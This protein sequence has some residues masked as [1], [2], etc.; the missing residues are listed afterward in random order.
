MKKRG[1][2]FKNPEGRPVGACSAQEKVVQYRL[3]HPLASVTEVARAL[4]ISRT[5]VYKWWNG[6]ANPRYMPKKMHN[7][8]VEESGEFDWKATLADAVGIPRE[9]VDEFLEKM[10]NKEE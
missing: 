5:T 1:V 3:E 4:K 10:K 2:P 7:K 9:N 6:E 8:P